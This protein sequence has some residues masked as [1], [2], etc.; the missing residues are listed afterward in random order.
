MD[1]GI[2]RKMQ[3][4]TWHRLLRPHFFNDVSQ[5]ITNYPTSTVFAGEGPV[6]G[7]FHPFLTMVFTVI[8]AHDMRGD[9]STRIVAFH[10]GRIGETLQ[11]HRL[12]LTNNVHID[13][14]SQVDKSVL[15]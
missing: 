7:Q 13:L 12:H 14:A 2:N 10:V 3:I 9:F 4:L 5:T 11:M 6:V 15:T 1:T 8:K